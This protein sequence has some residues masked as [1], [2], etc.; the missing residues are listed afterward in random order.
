FEMLDYKSFSF[1]VSSM[2]IAKKL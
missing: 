2:F 1:G